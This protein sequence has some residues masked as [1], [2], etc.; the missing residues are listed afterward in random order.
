M[1]NS[2]VESPP[3]PP[4]RAPATPP[5]LPT[6]IPIVAAPPSVVPPL[7]NPAAEILRNWNESRL[8]FPVNPRSALVGFPVKM[9]QRQS[10]PLI[11]PSRPFRSRFSSFRSRNDVPRYEPD[12]PLGD[13]LEYNRLRY[14]YD[15][16]SLDHYHH[17][18][19]HNP[20]RRPLRPISEIPKRR[21]VCYFEDDPLPD[22]VY[23]SLLAGPVYHYTAWAVPNDPMR[24]Y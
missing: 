10:A 20:P 8:P 23:Y 3:P 15:P 21:Y 14:S 12:Y 1:P 11:A 4:I 16:R 9:N 18:Q 2:P 6:P 24:I 19:Q 13:T 7:A 22:P 5:N 17:Q